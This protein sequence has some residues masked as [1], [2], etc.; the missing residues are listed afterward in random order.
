MASILNDLIM[1]LDGPQQREAQKLSDEAGR[2]T[3]GL[4]PIR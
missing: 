4:A 2:D 3:H 1:L